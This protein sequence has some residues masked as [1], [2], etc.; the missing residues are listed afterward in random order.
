MSAYDENE[1]YAIEAKESGADAFLIK[2]IKKG[3]LLFVVNFILRIEHLNETV[4][5]K[6][7]ELQEDQ[8]RLNNNLKTSAHLLWCSMRISRMV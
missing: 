6:N 1:D 3:E 4:L 8:H 5:D 2:P 7:H